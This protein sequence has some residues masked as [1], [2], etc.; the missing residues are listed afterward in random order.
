[1]KKNASMAALVLAG[2]KSSRMGEDKA[3]MTWE[4]K[5]MLQ[6]V[7]QT[8]A[9]FCN[10]V[11]I[12]SP[13]PERYHQLLEGNYELLLETNP[14]GGPLVALLQGLIMIST[15]LSV[16]WLWL[17]ACDLPR[18]QTEK[19]QDWINQLSEVEQNSYA[20]VPQNQGRWEPLCG[21]YR[22]EVISPLENFIAQGGR[23]FQQ[24]LCELPTTAIPVGKEEAAML[25][26][27]NRPEDFRL[28]NG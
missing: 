14:G 6:R 20:I 1:M 3:L 7:C 26:N 12:L 24:W 17:L 11:Y 9:V 13:W 16:D 21:F 19:L 23:S 5:P 22:L 28:V 25:W 15:R 27:C 18:L 2:G 8:A 10:S 4:G